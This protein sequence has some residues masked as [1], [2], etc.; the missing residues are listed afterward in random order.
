[1]V[2]LSDDA[3]E[4]ADEPHDR[5]AHF[6]ADADQKFLAATRLAIASPMH[7][8]VAKPVRYAV[9]NGN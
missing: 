6:G 3:C 1:M 9:A 8:R 2:D 5:L 7:A 4:V